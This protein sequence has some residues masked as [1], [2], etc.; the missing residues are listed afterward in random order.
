MNLEEKYK[1]KI[2]PSLVKKYGNLMAVP[3]LK[4]IVVNI[5]FGKEIS[6]KGSDEQRKFI[7]S[8]SQDLAL[9]TGQKPALTRARKSIAGFKLRQGTPVGLR[10]TLRKKRMWSFLEKLINVALPR[11][12]DFKGIKSESL[13]KQGNLSF[14]VKEQI[15]FPEVSAEQ[16]KN[17]FG[18]QITV[19]LTTKRKEDGLEFLK[20]IGFPIK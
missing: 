19:T 15:I 5:G 6:A 11:S 12:R 2:R 8:L 14:G 13:D 7:Q 4:Q 17:I 1:K 9:I 16:M 20:E 18:F 3:N 10:V